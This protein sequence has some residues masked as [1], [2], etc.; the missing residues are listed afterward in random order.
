MARN[1]NRKVKRI[2]EKESIEMIKENIIKDLNVKI[3]EQTEI[4]RIFE[5][6]L[7]HKQIFIDYAG[8]TVTKRLITK[9]EKVMRG[10]L[11]FTLSGYFRSFKIEIRNRMHRVKCVVIVE[12]EDRKLKANVTI[13]NIS[14][15][16]EM[17]KNTIESYKQDIEDFD[18]MVQEFGKIDQQV[19]Q[20]NKRFSAELR[21]YLPYCQLYVK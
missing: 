19:R 12:T 20:F 17:T 7:E 13:N 4:L 6:L 2:L 16:I 11:D 10:E 1:G 3:K 5:E 18:Q 15:A 14:Q 21:D 9:L 8:K